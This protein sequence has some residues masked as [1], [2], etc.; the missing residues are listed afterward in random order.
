LKFIFKTKKKR[1][2]GANMK[3]FLLVLLFFSMLNTET[4][5]DSFENPSQRAFIPDT[6][7]MYAFNFF[8]PNFNADVALKG[9]AQGS[10]K[11]RLFTNM[12]NNSALKI[13][14]QNY[15]QA[16]A[17]ANVY[18]L[19]AKMY[20]SLNGDEEI[21]LSWQLKTEGRASFSDE[22]IAALNGPGSFTNGKDYTNILDDRYYYQT[23]HQI[24]FTYHE[25]INKQLAL[26]F[27]L[28]GL[29]GVQYQQLNVYSSNA[30]F[31][32]AADSARA[33]LQGTY[34]AGFIPGQFISRDYLPSLRSPG[35]S[36]TAGG[37]YTTEDNI[38]IQGAVKDLGFIH[39]DALSRTYNFDNSATF[40]NL[41][42][43]SREDT[44]Y[45]GIRKIIHN[46]STQGSFTTPIDGHAELSVN[47]TFYL[48]D[49]HQFKYSP[50]LAV[51]KELF[52]TGYDV[53]LVNP[54]EY[55]KYSLALTPSY[56]AV[57]ALSLG[58]RFMVR[59][60]DW[61]FFIGSDRLFQTVSTT[62]E[63]ISKSSQS[64]SQTTSGYSGANIFIGFSLKLG[65][66]I[67]HHMNASSIPTGEPGFLGRLFGRLFKTYDN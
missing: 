4:L 2:R 11:S 1:P 67:E 26:G 37:T 64:I 46:N 59:T 15:S 24:S 61:E 21:G 17:S 13:G 30:T 45:N 40:L 50:T 66:V 42:S 56:D 58:L 27:K 57:T 54:I 31:D 19:M 9:D 41:T 5:Y 34:R 44:I 53:A 51:S 7:K 23:Y 33:N 65:P 28:S 52:Y 14:D 16:V 49:D 3:K 39:W 20:S 62:G 48:D 38:H 35:A 12:Y 10:L 29:L 47:K 25:R 8:L 55:Q 6:S 22:S 18:I 36:I 60:Y 32:T 63:A 43:P